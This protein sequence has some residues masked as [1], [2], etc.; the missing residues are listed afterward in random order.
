M[1]IYR[2]AACPTCDGTGRVTCEEC[3]GM[4]KIQCDLCNGTG[5]RLVH[6]DGAMVAVTCVCE[7]GLYVCAKCSGG[8][9]LCGD[10]QGKG[11]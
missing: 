10:C 4:G 11:Y 3:G 5:R 2:G 6:R 8:T 7:T 9:G 1:S